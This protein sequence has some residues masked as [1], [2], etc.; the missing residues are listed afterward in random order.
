MPVVYF[1]DLVYRGSPTYKK[2]T[3]AVPY[4]HG[5]GLCMRKLGNFALVV[6]LLQSSPTNM[7]FNFATFGSG[8][9]TLGKYL[10]NA[11]LG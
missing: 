7:N 5:F 11:I 8:E 6:D 10:A 3:E 9:V 4:F 2:I 1:A